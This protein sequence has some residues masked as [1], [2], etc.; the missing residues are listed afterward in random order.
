MVAKKDEEEYLSKARI[1][2]EYEFTDAMIRDFLPEPERTAPN[3]YYK[4]T[5]AVVQL[6]SKST[7]EKVVA[8]DEFVE[9]LK[10]RRAR[11]SQRKAVAQ[12]KREK[13]FDEYCDKAKAIAVR[14]I[15][16]GELEK[17]AL[18]AKENRERGMGNLDFQAWD[19]PD[20][21]RR[22]WM[23]NYVRHNLTVYDRDLYEMKGK[24]G[25]HDGYEVY[26]DAVLDKIAD[27][28]PELAAECE[29]QKIPVGDRVMRD[30]HVAS[31]RRPAG[32]RCDSR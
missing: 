15:S 16:L 30:L 23:V 31:Q 24:V 27:I 6:W 11:G 20:Y 19:A 12:A 7:I 5:G 21:V 9:R 1:K 28:Y 4:T 3:P 2:V 17:R 8:S 13:T 25:V 22:R 18:E 32:G 14:K 26:K 29:D 10:K